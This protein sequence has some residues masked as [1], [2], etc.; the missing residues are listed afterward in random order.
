MPS[1]TYFI[2]FVHR[3]RTASTPYEEQEY[4]NLADAWES[5]RLFA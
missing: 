4:I 1:I 3:D 2:R 5:F